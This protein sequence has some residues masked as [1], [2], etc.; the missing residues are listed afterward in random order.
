[1]SRAQN[2]LSWHSARRGALAADLALFALG[3]DHIESRAY[4][5]ATLAGG[6]AGDFIGFYLAKPMTDAEAHGTSHGSTV[7]AALT[8]GVLGTAGSYKAR[9]SSRV[10]SAVII[11]AGALGYPLGL[12][13]VRDAPY[14]VTDGDVG[15]LVTTELLGLGVAGTLIPDRASDATAYG[16]LTAGFAAGAIVGDRLLVRPFDHTEAESRLLQLGAEAGALL[17][18]TI[19]TLGQSDNRQTI[20]ASATIGGI[21][22]AVIAEGMLAPRRARAGERGDPARRTGAAGDAHQPRVDVRFAPAAVVMAGLGQ[23][24]HH[25]ILS[26]S[27]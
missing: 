26:L 6:L 13:Y 14:R 5:A 4:G 23:R 9:G 12:R 18:L 27:F 15:T 10:A 24:G 7:T 2:H 22:G 1:V 11:G 3:G 25:S 20:L 8:A 21:F 19:P 16:L 17:G